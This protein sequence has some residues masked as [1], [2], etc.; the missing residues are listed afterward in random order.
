M[1]E[2]PS[3]TSTTLSI[4][5]FSSPFYLHHGDSP[6]SLL[7]SQPLN[8]DNYLTWKRFM[9]LALMAKNK[10]SFV[11]GTLPKPSS[12]DPTLHAWVRCN[13][14]VLSWILNSV[15]KEIANSV[16]FLNTAADMWEDLKE[17]FSQ[18]NGLRV[19]QLQKAI[20]TLTQGNHSVSSYYTHLKGLW[21]E[22]SNIRPIPNCS[23]GGL[24]VFL[25]FHH[26]EYVFHFL[27]GLNESFSRIRGQILLID[28]MPSINK[29]FSLVLQEE[30]QREV[31]FSH[32]LPTDTA[33]LMSKADSNPQNQFSRLASFRK[34]HPTCT[35]CG[36]VGHVVDKCCKLHGYPPKSNKGKITNH[37]AHQ[38]QES[39][40]ES[41]QLS[42]T[43][44]QCKQ[45][46]ALLKL[47]L[48]QE[49]PSVN[50]SR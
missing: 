37:S 13:N 16:I 36:L 8:G 30:R 47:Q 29:V 11:D 38:V 17:R 5:N 22:L 19:F 1:S 12:T 35:H 25:G 42:I 15:S 3:S 40:Q 21:D 43:Q 4:E 20:S 49:S 45:L 46:L 23:C 31:A 28:P 44:E 41:A 6:V 14:M 39:S 7:V 33:A 32:S 48:P 24:K 2:P 10:F 26:Q 18:S 50:P 34:E 9:M 27:M